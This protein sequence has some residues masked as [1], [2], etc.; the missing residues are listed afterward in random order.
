MKPGKVL[1][2]S[3]FLLFFFFGL[4]RA[5]NDQFRYIK[6]QPRAIDFSTRLRGTTTEFEGFIPRNL[7]LRSIA[8]GGILIH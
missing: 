3:M 8:S 5:Q 1:C 2:C 4:D 6:I 7:V